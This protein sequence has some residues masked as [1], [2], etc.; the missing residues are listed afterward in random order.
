MLVML[1]CGGKTVKDTWFAAMVFTVTMRLPVVAPVGTGTV[2]EP[3]AQVAGVALVPLNVM[4]LVI[5]PKPAPLMVTE[6]PIGA[7]P[8]DTLV[9]TGITTNVCVLLELPLTATA[10]S[11]FPAA[12]LLG[13]A[14]TIVVSLQEEGVAETPPNVTVLVP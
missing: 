2:I 4:A 8:G 12:R 13:T 3:P 9:M 10:I 1:G 7:E 14:T 11:A 6:A 5:V